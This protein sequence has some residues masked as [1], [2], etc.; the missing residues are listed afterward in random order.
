MLGLRHSSRPRCAGPRRMSAGHGNRRTDMDGNLSL[1]RIAGIRVGLNWSLVVVML[2]LA[3]SLA[4]GFFPSEVP[5]LPPAWYW[6]AGITAAIV[7]LAALLA[8]ELAHSV[9][10][11]RSGVRVEGITLWLFGGVSRLSGEAHSART[12][13]LIT[14]VGPATSLVLGGLFLLLGSALPGGHQPRLLFVT[15]TWLGTVNLVLGLFNLI[16]AAPLDGG[17]LLRALVWAWTGDR[18][19]ATTIASRAGVGFGLLLIAFGLF[20]FFAARSPI[21]GLWAVFLGWFLLSAARSEESSALVRRA[22]AGVR[23]A[24]VMT[25]HPIEAPEEISVEDLLH[26]FILGHRHSTFPVHDQRGDLTGLVTIGAVKTVRPEA[27]PSTPVRSIACPR[28]QVPTAGPDESLAS[29]LERM[30]GCGDGRALVLEDGRLV[31]LVSPSDI[32]RAVQRSS[33]GR[34]TA[35]RP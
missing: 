6:V 31:G 28:D 20:T 21:A 2:L 12:E 34:S 32:S 19:R 23:V 11:Q 26:R 18:L 22:L 15:L 4:A 27:R 7:F 10:A 16:P 14:L 30:G 13:A 5:G 1:G 8:H 3:W 17:R 25:P 33:L 35:A 9:V 24:D 29:L